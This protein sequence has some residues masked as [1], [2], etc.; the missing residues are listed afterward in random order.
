MPNLAATETGGALGLRTRT[1]RLAPFFPIV[2]CGIVHVGV[3]PG[4]EPSLVMESAVPPCLPP[5]VA[6]LAI[7]MANAYG[8]PVTTA[9]GLS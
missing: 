1:T 9:H 2:A 8:R 7:G 3:H 4:A 6:L 5:I